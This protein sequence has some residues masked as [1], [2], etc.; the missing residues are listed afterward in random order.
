MFDW[1]GNGKI[2]P[3]DIGISVAAEPHENVSDIELLGYPF[4]YI[5]ELEP[6]RNLL[7]K[8]KQYDPKES[9]SKKGSIQ[10]NKYGTGPFCRF[11][12][13]AKGNWGI[14]GVYALFDN[15]E[16]LYL[17]QTENFEQRFNTGYGNISPRN[18]YIGGQN[19]NCKINSMILS[20]YLTGKKVYLFFFKTA[21]YDC[22]EH[23]LIRALKPPYNGAIEVERAENCNRPF[24]K[25]QRTNIKRNICERGDSSLKE[26]FEQCILGKIESMVKDYVDLNS[27]DIHR[28]VGGYPGRNHQM[29]T[30]CGVMYQLMKGSDEVISS[31]PSG[32]GAS[33]TIRYYK[34]NH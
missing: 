19:T 32:K 17:G 29:P 23:E 3:V 27:G 7:G 30:C 16:L 24:H 1:N 8:I 22:V 14:C 26:L 9:F 33:V 13:K 5:Q 20:K 18:C 21:N 4:E 10:L 12:I 15:Q 31:P 2:D 6:D 34:K 25:E 28:K 11:S